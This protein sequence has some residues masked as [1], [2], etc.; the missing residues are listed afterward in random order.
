MDAATLLDLDAAR[1]EHPGISG[2]A[3]RFERNARSN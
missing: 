3:D 2:A 1:P